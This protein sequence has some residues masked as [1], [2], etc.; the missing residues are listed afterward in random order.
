MQ[1]RKFG[2]LD[3]QAS[4]LGFGC[5]RLPTLGG[6]RSLIDEV[7]ATRMLHYAIDHGVNYLDTAY[8]YHGG[9][10]ERFVGRALQG[11][12]REKVMLATKLPVRM[13]ERTEDFDR[14][15]DEQLEKLQTDHI[16]FYLFHGLRAPRWETVC[17]LGLLD[18][19]ERALA[20]G[21]IRHLGFSFHDTFEMF[22]QII[23]AYEGWTMCQIQ[24]NYMNEKDQAGTSG[25]EYAASK[26]L[27]VV[28]ME[29]LLG[30]KLVDPPPSIQELWD[31]AKVRRSP[32]AWAFHWLWNKPQVSVALSGMSAMEQVVENVA[33]ASV[34]GVGSLTEEELDL[35]ARVRSKY[36]EICPIPCT[37]CGYCMPCPNGVDIPGNFALLNNAAMYN[38][39][40]DARRR[41]GR[42]PEGSRASACIQCRECEELCPQDILI[43]EWMPV[44]HQV[45]GEGKPYEQCALPL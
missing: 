34:S 45:L 9:N 3:W 20:D 17:T 23:D 28:V 37:R 27:A 32:A 40:G 18:R 8:P 24:Y 36:A 33:S 38:S 10:S 19:A 29:P 39:Y 22:K 41:Y 43:S 14:F 11:G 16:D 26:G 6:D 2:K 12:Y 5:M 13:V 42:M 1:H 4:A 15:L 7:E 30:G 31:E 25:L 21:K 35:V 44:V